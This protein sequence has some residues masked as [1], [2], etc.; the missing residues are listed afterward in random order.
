MQARNTMLAQLPIIPVPLWLANLSPASILEDPFP[1]QSLLQDSLYY[2][3]SGFDGDPVMYLVGNI[4]SFIYVDYGYTRDRLEKEL[5]ENGF[6]GYN[7]LASRSVMKRELTPHGWRP[8]PPDASEDDPSREIDWIK[9]PYCVWS[10]LERRE[11]VSDRNRP[12]RFSLLYLCADGVAAFQALYVANSAVPKAVA[13][14]QPGHGF[15]RNWTDFKDRGGV[16]A[17]SVMDNPNGQPE[18]LLDGGMG[19]RDFYR[20]PCWP[21]Y[22]QLVRI[23]D[24]KNYDGSIGI[25]KTTTQ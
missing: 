23:V 8:V 1:L 18:L 11:S 12:A 2:P 6:R 25:W 20:E 13:I 24:K 19:P 14:I 7:V 16:F 17:R 21:E 10:V 15:G 9:E 22:G 3:S 4:L 5:K